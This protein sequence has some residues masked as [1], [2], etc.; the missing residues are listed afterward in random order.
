MV[1]EC[2]EEFGEAKHKRYKILSKAS[3]LTQNKT[4]LKFIKG[5]LFYSEILIAR[6]MKKSF[7]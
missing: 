2:R 1:S 6:Q 3:N 5:V 7:L 4:P